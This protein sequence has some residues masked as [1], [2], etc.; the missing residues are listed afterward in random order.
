M[1]KEFFGV[2]VVVGSL[3][4]AKGHISICHSSF[5]AGFDVLDIFW[6][7]SI[8]QI[9]RPMLN[10]FWKLLCSAEDGPWFTDFNMHQQFVRYYLSQACILTVSNIFKFRN[11]A[12]LEW[13]NIII[14][15]LVS[16]RWNGQG[17]EEHGT[18]L[19]SS[20][21][22]FFGMSHHHHHLL[23]IQEMKWPR[24]QGAHNT[25]PLKQNS[26]HLH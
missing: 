1:L 18:L 3:W 23:G 7:D 5:P 10:F 26:L 19:P 25:A 13:V 20:Q 11:S 8:Y 2:K 17:C 16:K 15:R 12:F 24:L 21:T 14:V 9:G 4:A 6:I 22:K